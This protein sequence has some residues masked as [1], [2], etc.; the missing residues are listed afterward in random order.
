M[1]GTWYKTIAANARLILNQSPIK[2]EFKKAIPDNIIMTKYTTRGG[3]LESLSHFLNSFGS[4][5]MALL[6][7]KNAAWRLLTR[8][9]GSRDWTV[10]LLKQRYNAGR[11]FEK[12]QTRFGIFA[13]LLRR[14]NQLCWF[15]PSPLEQQYYSRLK[16]AR[17]VFYSCEAHLIDERAR[18]NAE[19]A[20][21]NL[22]NWLPGLDS[23]QQPRS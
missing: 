21:F 9:S 23:N 11:R 10:P 7:T 17:L 13:H 4:F 19:M 6:Y 1:K 22:N 5:F 12:S 2:R 8:N 20:P 16:D 14:P 18:K 3:S 15:S